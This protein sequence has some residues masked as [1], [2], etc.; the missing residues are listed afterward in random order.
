MDMRTE[1]ETAVLNALDSVVE[2]IYG[3]KRQGWR[4][5]DLNNIIPWINR[6]ADTIE[7]RYN[8]ARGV[9]LS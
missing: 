6:H 1:I 2:R 7:K 3:V 9:P 8:T 5:E 4:D